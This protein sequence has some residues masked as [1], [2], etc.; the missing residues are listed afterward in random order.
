MQG[1]TRRLGR[2]RANALLARLERHLN[3]AE[4]ERCQ[5][6]VEVLDHSNHQV[7]VALALAKL[8]PGTS[9][10]SGN[11]ALSRLVSRVNEAAAEG[12]INLRLC[13]TEAR[14][15]G[16]DRRGLWFEGDPMAEPTHA[17]EELDRVGQKLIL[18]TRGQPAGTE[19]RLVLTESRE[20][21]PLVR[22]FMSYAHENQ[23][24]AKELFAKLNLRLRNAS[25]YAFEGWH[26][27]SI[28]VGESWQRS[29]TTQLREAQLGVFLV[30]HA[31]LSSKFITQRELPAFVTGHA[32]GAHGKRV[33]P[34]LLENMNLEST[35][36]KGL[37]ALQI[38]RDSE[39][40]AFTQRNRRRREAWID[41]LV[42]HILGVLARHAHA[43]NPGCVKSE[44]EQSAKMR[45]F[46]SN[47]MLSPDLEQVQAPVDDAQGQP[48]GLRFSFGSRSRPARSL[49]VD[50]LSPPEASVNVRDYLL[51]WVKERASPRLF[52]LLG[53]YGMG[54]T[55]SCQRL[56]K[57]LEQERAEDASL[58]EPLY[59]DL[60]M[61]TGLK[62]RT[63]PPTLHEI[64]DECV[65]RGW[66]ANAGAERPSAEDLLQRASRQAVLFIFDGLD[67]ALVH[68]TEAD[69]QA[70]TRELLRLKPRQVT[71][72]TGQVHEATR[73]LISCRTHFFRTLRAQ[74]N[75]F[76][77]QERDNTPA[78]D[79]R[80]L[81]L[82]PFS[83]SQIYAYLERALPSF[84]VNAVLEIVGSVH[85]LSELARRPYTLKLV[86]EL[87]PE[88]E[89]WRSE[90]R[91]VLGITLYRQLVGR[92]M[93][94]DSGKH[95]LR[96]EHK[97]RLMAHLSAWLWSRGERSVSVD[98]LEP[99]FHDWLEQEPD[100]RLRYRELARDKL[101]EDL[102]TATFLVRQDDSGDT[103]EGSFRFAHTSLQ[104]FFLAQY[105]YDAVRTGRREA[106]AIPPVSDETLGFF[107]E[108]LLESR[109]AGLM[110]RFG[111]WRAP[112]LPGATEQWLRYA[113]LG[114]E[115]GWPTPTLSGLDCR[116]A[117]LPGWRFIGRSERE[118][119]NL[120]GANFCGANLR[121]S[122][123]HDVRLDR[124]SL[125][126]AQ[127][128]GAEWLQVRAPEATFTDVQCDGATFRHCAWSGS[129]W[130]GAEGHRPKFLFSEIPA[131]WQRS[132][133]GDVLVASST[134]KELQASSELTRRLA[135]EGGHPG[136]VRALAYSPDGLRA[137]SAGDHGIIF[138][139][140]ARAGHCLNAFC[141][142][143]GSVNA[144]VYSPDGSRV[145]SASDD[146]TLRLWDVG[147][148]RCLFD[149]CGHGKAVTGCAFAPDGTRAISSS[150]DYTLKLWDV[151]SGECLDTWR[152]HSAAVTACAV[153]P[154]GAHAVSSSNDGT[155]RLWEMSSG[156]SSVI[157]ERVQRPAASQESMDCCVFSP[158]GRYV[159]SGSEG[160]GIKLWDPSSHQCLA[161]WEAETYARCCF[162]SPDGTEII[163][164]GLGGLRIWNVETGSGR[165]VEA[166]GPGVGPGVCAVSPNG[167]RALS[168]GFGIVYVHDLKSG[169]QLSRWRSRS[170]REVQC[171][172]TS[173]GT[174]LISVS[175]GR[176][177]CWEVSSGQCTN[178]W[179]IESVLD[180]TALSPDGRRVIRF[181]ENVHVLDS[182]SGRELAKW[183]GGDV[184]AGMCAF[185]ADG[186]RF[187]VANG[188]GM[189]LWDVAS[190]QQLQKW[191]VGKWSR[192]C[193]LSTDGAVLATMDTRS[194][195]LWQTPT[196]ERLAEWEASSPLTGNCVFSRD[197]R[198]LFSSSREGIA[199]YDLRSER[200]LA[201]WKSSFSTRCA[202]SPDGALLASGRLGG[203]IELWDTAS[204]ER[205]GAWQAHE[206][207]LADL[208][209]SPDGKRLA[210]MTHDGALRAWEVPS[211]RAFW[212][213]EMVRE[214]HAVWNPET[215][216]LVEATG[217]AWRW[218][219]CRL[220]DSDGRLVDVWPAEALGPFPPARR[221]VAPRSAWSGD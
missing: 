191:S 70:F 81:V 117:D 111:S 132:R 64:I 148:G 43:D 115:L 199:V 99:W 108:L 15:V 107:A 119:L 71:T 103:A 86:A 38:F 106:W 16:A 179:A 174:Q 41:E 185:S 57:D 215:Q 56:V 158:D 2:A 80:A 180:R 120:S 125:D 201:L 74:L 94:R 162:F 219:V 32:E 76:T 84:D 4:L 61:L 207:I 128:Q 171:G 97:W 8:F 59:F 40:K 49:D 91:E 96:P 192:E 21:K 186:T 139:W 140:D 28:V 146:G 194:V 5:R 155:V 3:A 213:I 66:R 47:M 88:L 50:V 160:A 188:G 218:L 63:H 138:V 149:L 65:T 46:P 34:V 126:G 152:G 104:E 154:D 202:L 173:D 87:V 7:S 73:V 169:R 136:V 204:G 25:R 208:A 11:K 67:E 177:R 187:A 114:M 52:A 6:L 29:I 220:Y 196:G 89:R 118:P 72:Y 178:K 141:G 151:T 45:A 131:P 184:G 60:R 26:D 168:A 79:Y 95:H 14:S 157:G 100:L 62:Q 156:S 206:S 109:E 163:S 123:W 153:S 53:E 181:G 143:T 44:Q 58:P 124:A 193:A 165:L 35:D 13:I 69:G 166:E 214:D 195:R 36:L 127:F 55:I 18:D 197:G 159:V 98:A 200:E 170:A 142:H 23:K 77:G 39:R 147:T 24:D 176:V 217:G 122:T 209:F 31:F 92:W 20:G 78:S 129:S 210:S 183:S 33:I 133:R 48:T 1:Q 203:G 205:L 51:D 42:E 113:L 175:D 10:S 22:W 110:E 221:L 172:F 37:E 211:G 161:T 116:G 85:N 130:R 134:A 12:H 121:E 75:H 9:L 145:L 137:I 68:F 90:G 144:C 112:Y 182:S 212:H 19:P 82:L 150:N 30:S 54:K 105:L 101:D 216:K 102:R 27:G 83:E 93:S 135:R 189:A 17:T 164:S 190:G 167:S 198:R